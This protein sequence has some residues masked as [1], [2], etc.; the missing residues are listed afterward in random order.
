VQAGELSS[1]LT[2]WLDR[3]M[4]DTARRERLTA[5]LRE[6]FGADARVVDGEICA[7]MQA[8]A[9]TVSRHLD[10]EWVPEGG[11]VPDAEP[12]GWPPQDP[13]EV[14]S[15][16]ASIAA[17]RVGDAG[18]LEVATLDTLEHAAPFLERSFEALRGV[19]AVVLDLRA[20]GGGDPATLAAVLGR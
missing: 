9:R 19:R 18:V 5:A 8:L 3:L 20:N 16:G 13:L 7:E 11:L 2:A 14:A 4:P 12:P 17:R 1:A 15:R 10:V 6:R